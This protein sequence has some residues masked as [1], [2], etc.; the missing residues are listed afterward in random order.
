[1]MRRVIDSPKYAMNSFQAIAK[2]EKTVVDETVIDAAAQEP[3]KTIVD[4]AQIPQQIHGQIFNIDPSQ[5][6]F[7]DTHSDRLVNSS[8]LS[9]NTSLMFPPRFQLCTMMIPTYSSTS[10]LQC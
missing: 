2:A 4:E 3:K 9:D 1:M 7:S 5:R 6:E 8:V 10:C